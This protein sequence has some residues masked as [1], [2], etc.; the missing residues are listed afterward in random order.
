MKLLF[1]G[2]LIWL[3]KTVGEGGLLGVLGLAFCAMWLDDVGCWL[4]LCG[5]FSELSSEAFPSVSICLDDNAFDLP[6]LR[7]WLYSAISPHWDVGL[8]PLGLRKVW[9][10]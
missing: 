6:P 4:C 8:G 1:G 9:R 5:F 3:S 10:A 2:G 7:W